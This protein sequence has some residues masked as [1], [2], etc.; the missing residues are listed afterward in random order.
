MLNAKG[1]SKGNGGEEIAKLE[2][3]HMLRAGKPSEH[4]VNDS[5]TGEYDQWNSPRTF[6]AWSLLFPR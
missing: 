5:S 3:R 6:D 2:A 1:D 4:Q